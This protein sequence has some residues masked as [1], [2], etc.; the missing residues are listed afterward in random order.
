MKK[1]FNIERT[2]VHKLKT[3]DYTAIFISG[4]S[5]E[6]LDGS[7]AFNLE[8]NGKSVPFELKK[9]ERSDIS[10]KFDFWP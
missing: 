10:K 2:D 8:V 5:L 9:F 6:L 7:A 3:E 4:W 1:N